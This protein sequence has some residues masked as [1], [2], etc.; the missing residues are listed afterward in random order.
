M[1]DKK[2]TLNLHSISKL[3]IGTPISLYKPRCV[4]AHDGKKEV[5]VG[6]NTFHPCVDNILNP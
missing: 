6:W 2:H 4:I 3:K 5:G 1:G